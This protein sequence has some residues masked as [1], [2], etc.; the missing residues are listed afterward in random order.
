MRTRTGHSPGDWSANDPCPAVTHRRAFEGVGAEQV[1]S[2][3]PLLT[4]GG[5][6]V[7]WKGQ[8]QAFSIH[9]ENRLRGEKLAEKYPMRPVCGAAMMYDE[10]CGRVKG[11]RPSHRSRTIMDADA[12]RRRPRS[13]L[14]TVA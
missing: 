4:S 12:A 9:T 1:G 6:S 8:A 7:D 2:M 11:H 13:H 5:N 10:T 3:R 14:E